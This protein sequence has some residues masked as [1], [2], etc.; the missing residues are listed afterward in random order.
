MKNYL[1][2]GLIGRVQL[3]HEV[4]LEAL[5][6]SLDFVFFV[7]NN[8]CVRCLDLEKEICEHHGALI[9][10]INYREYQIACLEFNDLPFVYSFPTGV[11]VEKG[12]VIDSDSM[13]EKTSIE[14]Y[15]WLISRKEEKITTI[16]NPFK[17]VFAK[18][19]TL[20]RYKAD[21]ESIDI[22]ISE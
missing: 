7:S 19:G 3:D 1:I 5:K 16:D 17:P 21:K 2:N 10:E 4:L 8:G 11:I 13:G 12:K 14:F 9:F 20:R 18:D 22:L 15:E 6:K